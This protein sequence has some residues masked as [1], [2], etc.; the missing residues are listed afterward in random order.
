MIS[1]N[2]DSC[3]YVDIIVAIYIYVAE[4]TSI[5]KYHFIRSHVQRKKRSPILLRHFQVFVRYALHAGGQKEL[6]KSY[7]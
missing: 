6:L 4:K 1:W 5:G 2:E 3:F 7:Y